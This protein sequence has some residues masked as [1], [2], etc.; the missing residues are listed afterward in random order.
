M[1]KEI[2]RL[3]L[4]EDNNDR[5]ELFQSWLPEEFRL[6]HAGSAGRALGVLQRDRNAYAGLLLDHDLQEQVASYPARS[7]AIR[8]RRRFEDHRARPTCHTDPG[9][10]HEPVGRPKDA[11]KIGKYRV[12][13]QPSAD[14]CHDR[15]IFQ[16]LARR[17]QGVLE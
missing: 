13:G 1:K 8:D 11:E 17:C 9:A 5:V 15:T 4:I 16:E 10:L 2:I 3:L 12:H 6:V 14:G 7:I